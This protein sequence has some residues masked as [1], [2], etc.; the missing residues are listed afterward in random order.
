MKDF[1]E[2]ESDEEINLLIEEI[3]KKMVKQESKT[4][5]KPTI[6]GSSKE[7]KKSLPGTLPPISKKQTAVMASSKF[8]VEEQLD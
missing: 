5:A 8:F 2:E 3:N 6:I 1:D 7:D 4:L